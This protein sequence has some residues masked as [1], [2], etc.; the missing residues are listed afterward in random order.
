LFHWL[1]LD[2][3]QCLL[4]QGLKK[5]RGNFRVA[6]IF[7]GEPV[8]LVLYHTI[9]LYKNL[10]EWGG[11]KKLVSALFIYL[12]G[13][14]FFFLVL[15]ATIFVGYSS[16]LFFVGLFY[17][18]KP[19][20][21]FE[22]SFISLIVPAKN[23][24]ERIAS[25]L[26]QLIELDYP[27]DKFE[28]IVSEDGS[29]DSTREVSSRW[30]N[31]FKDRMKLVFTDKSTG[32]PAALNRALSVSKGEIIGVIDADSSVDDKKLLQ[33]VASAFSRPRVKAVQG[34]TSV[35][36]KNQGLLAKLTSFE[37]EVWNRFLLRGRANLNLFVP[38]L[39]NLTFVRRSILEEV[40]G[41]KESMLAEDVE[42][43]ITMW[44]KGYKFEYCPDVKCKELTVSKVK[45][46]I[47]QRT[48]WYGGYFQ[49][50]A[51][52]GDLLKKKL[53]PT[54]LD[55][56]ALLATPLVGLLGLTIFVL[57][58]VSFLL[59]INTQQIIALTPYTLGAYT[60][61]SSVATFAVFKFEG[62]RRAW[63]LLPII[64]MYWGLE[65]LVSSFALIKVLTKRKLT[66]IRTPK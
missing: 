64:Y 22:D 8:I 63:T 5:N 60:T 41:W 15:T 62:K 3:T 45:G 38:S 59:G 24:E 43:S 39:G 4:R 58:I 25:L 65:A 53:S 50:L 21:Y 18:R 10:F 34:E 27:K 49:S 30:V 56:E 47:T 37:H 52:H 19:P 44:I 51:K 26:S 32:K 46:F 57:G 48:R 23:E 28:V 31:K 17:K 7:L 14:V 35:G 55:G 12:L 42:L 6:S 2:G 13:T 61:F 36:N 20:Q 11:K 33:N 1:Y 54:S 40:G 29:T 66:W 9:H 16:T